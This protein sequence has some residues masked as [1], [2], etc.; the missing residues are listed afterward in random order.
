METYWLGRMGA[1]FHRCDEV[2]DYHTTRA[3]QR[4]LSEART[5]GD[6]KSGQI[7]D[8]CPVDDCNDKDLHRPLPPPRDIIVEITMRDAA[9]WFSTS[10][11]LPRCTLQHESVEQ[12]G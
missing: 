7:I 4:R 5:I 1:T 3:M 10:V 8:D 12:P 11:M 2:D 9:K 6:A